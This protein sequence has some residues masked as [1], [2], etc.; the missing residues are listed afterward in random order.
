MAKYKHCQ[1]DAFWS[2]F[3]CNNGKLKYRMTPLMTY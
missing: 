1:P 2:T 3:M